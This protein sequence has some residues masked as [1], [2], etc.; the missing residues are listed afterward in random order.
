MSRRAASRS[1]RTAGAS[2]RSSSS[3]ISSRS[4]RSACAALPGVFPD[5]TPFRM[6]DDDPLPAP[7]DVGADVRDQR[8]HLAVPLRR[9]GELE[10]ARTGGATSSCATT[11]ANCRRATRV[12]SAGDPAMLEV[13]RAADA[14]PARSSEV[15]E[16]YACVPLAHVVE[17]R[18]DQQVV[19]DDTVHSDG[20]AP[21]GGDPP[22]HVLDRAARP[23]PP[24]R[25]SARRPRGGDRPRRRPR[26]CRLPDA[27]GHQP[28]R[29][30]AG[31]LRRVGRRPSRKQLYRFCVVG[32][33]RAGD[34]HDDRRNGRRSF[35]RTGTTVCGSLRT[36]DRRR[37]ANR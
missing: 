35:R 12:A 14:A 32:R 7:I 23:A 3:A 5:G 13:A 1:C 22:G 17:C 19:L 28:L 37:C 31:A 2:P 16:A 20:A 18:A 9:A 8:L 25:R 24:A 26:S 4:A 33:G 29:A 27:A 6:P 15:T 36:G 10:A 30:A 34:V 21:A 11:S